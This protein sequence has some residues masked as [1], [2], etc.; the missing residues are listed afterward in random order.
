[1][2][3]WNMSNGRPID[4]AYAERRARNEPLTEVVQEKGE[5]ETI[6]ELSAND[7]F[8][9]FEVWDVLLTQ[10]NV[11]SKHHGSYLRHA[12]ARRLVVQ[13]TVGVNPLKSGRVGGQAFQQ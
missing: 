12:Y 8:A 4:E 13:D 11:Q 2:Y 7:E 1:M 5:S 10:R 6:P 9:N 3:D